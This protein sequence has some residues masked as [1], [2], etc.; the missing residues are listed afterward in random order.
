MSCGTQHGTKFWLN[1]EGCGVLC[2]FIVYGLQLYGSYVVTWHILDPWVGITSL[3][4]IGHFLNFNTLTFL[5]I[6]SHWKCMTTDPGAVPKDA[7]PL[8]SDIQENDYALENQEAGTSKAA[9]HNKYRKYCKRCKAFKP[10]RAHHCSM[11]NRCIIKMDHHCPWVNNCVG[12]GNHKLF[13]LFLLYVNLTCIYSMTLMAFRYASCV[14]HPSTGRCGTAS[15]NIWVILLFAESLLFGLFT[16]CMM[17]DQSLVIFTNQ[18]QIDRLKNVQHE[19]VESYNEVFG[20]PSHISWEPE[21]LWPAPAP[22]PAAGDIRRGRIL[23]YCLDCDVP[24]IETELTPMLSTNSNS[25]NS[26]V[27]NI[28]SSNS[29]SI[30]SNNTNRDIISKV[31]MN[32]HSMENGR[33]NTSKEDME[34][35]IGGGGGGGGV[36]VVGVNDQVR[37]AMNEHGVLPGVGAGVG[38]STDDSQEDGSG[39]KIGLESRGSGSGSGEVFMEAAKIQSNE[40][41]DVT[42]NA[43]TRHDI[44][45]RSGADSN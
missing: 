12:L 3:T 40:N 21:W 26:N 31:Q 25:I 8:P 22:I 4:G 20:G 30:S 5:G 9:N 18:T 24:A 36:S 19:R 42:N 32:S 41:G 45:K 33:P 35:R 39:R 16:G 10:V 28:D 13:L 6:L 14:L 7:R 2:A 34:E 37:E 44:R 23:G 1:Y 15:S 29:G 38:I 43:A 27:D 11:C 17:G